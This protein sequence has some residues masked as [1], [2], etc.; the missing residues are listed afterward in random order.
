MAVA[1]VSDTC[2]YLPRKLVDN[3]AV[4]VRG[5]HDNAVGDA[6]ERLNTEATVVMEWTRGELGVAERRFLQELPSDLYQPLKIRRSFG[7]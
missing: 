3:G 6:R 5:N 7:W 2:H 4:A 1:I